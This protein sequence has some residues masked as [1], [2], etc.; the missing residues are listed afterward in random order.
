MVNIEG[1]NKL[2]YPVFVFGATTK[3][4]SE[5]DL[6]RRCLET[7]HP[8]DVFP[9]RLLGNRRKHTGQTNAVVVG[10]GWLNSRGNDL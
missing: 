9:R 3:Q 10:R 6:L 1:Q 2:V 5:R 4:S 7:L 8:R